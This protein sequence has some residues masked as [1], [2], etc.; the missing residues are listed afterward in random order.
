M[1]IQTP[2]GTTYNEN[3]FTSLGG[4]AFKLFQHLEKMFLRLASLSEA[5]EFHFPVFISAKELKKLDYF[6]SFPQLIH[7]PVSL[8]L[9]EENLRNFAQGEHMNEKGE[10][11]LTEVTPICE[12]L[13]PAACYHFYISHQDMNLPAT[14][15]FTT[16]AHCFRQEK[17]Y[18]PLRRQRNFNMREIVCIGTADEVKSFL[19]RYKDL[20]TKILIEL[21]LPVEWEIATDPF[22][23]P[24]SNPKFIMQQLDPVKQ[25][26]IF[27]KNQPEELSI[28][29]IN[30]HKN[31]FGDGFNIKVN[32]ETAFSGCVAFGLERWIYAITKV[33]GTDQSNWPKLEELKL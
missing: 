31:Y 9:D 7:F 14:Q 27:F 16:R 33:Y 8:K 22:F 5:E 19:A 11:Q 2:Q 25:E 20:M 3:G 17:F 21:K 23:D 28:G 24:E 10:I 32:N 26:M 15:Y 13:T 18:E 30:Y 12:C 29:S 1:N 4:S 6:K